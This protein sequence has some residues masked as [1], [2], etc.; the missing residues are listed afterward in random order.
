MSESSAAVSRVWEALRR[1]QEPEELVT[2]RQ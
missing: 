1:V 2:I